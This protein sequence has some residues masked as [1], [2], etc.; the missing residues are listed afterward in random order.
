MMTPSCPQSQKS[1]HIATNEEDYTNEQKDLIK[2]F[3]E[4]ELSS[5]E[6]LSKCALNFSHYE[7]WDVWQTIF[8]GVREP[9]QHFSAE[10]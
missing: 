10:E 7:F 3:F 4:L 1:F 8:I 9:S 6:R 5:F 2:L